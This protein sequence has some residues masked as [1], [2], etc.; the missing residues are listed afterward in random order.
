[1]KRPVPVGSYETK[2]PHPW[3]LCD[4]HGN[5]WEWCANLYEKTTS[6]VLRGGAWNLNGRSSRAAARYW[7][8]PTIKRNSF[9]LRV[10]APAL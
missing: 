10:L 9:G 3:G 4:M 2:F 1:M 8:A 7:F 5:V 6:R